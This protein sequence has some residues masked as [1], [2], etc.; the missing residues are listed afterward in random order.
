MVKKHFQDKKPYCL[1][2]NKILIGKNMLWW[3]TNLR[4]CVFLWWK[5]W[6]LM[7]CLHSL[8]ISWLLKDFSTEN[9]PLSRS[10]LKVLEAALVIEIIFHFL[11]R[12]WMRLVFVIEICRE[13][14]S[15]IRPLISRFL[16]VTFVFLLWLLF[17][18]KTIF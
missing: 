7:P 14:I 15:R 1:F 16:R 2:M 11:V 3:N 12:L 18:R 4:S 6:R 9:S 10:R 13:E 5:F 17:G 8:L